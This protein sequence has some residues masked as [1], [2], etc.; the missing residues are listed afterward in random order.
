[1][2]HDVSLVLNVKSSIMDKLCRFL[3]AD[4]MYSIDDLVRKPKLGFCSR[5]HIENYQIVDKD[6]T[7][8]LMFFEGT[9]TNLGCT[10]LLTGAS[11]SELAIIKAIT[12]L[13]I[14]VAYNSKLE[15]SFIMDKYSDFSLKNSN[16]T[17]NTHNA[18]K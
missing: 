17:Y 1:M 14:Y 2:Q 4:P 12:K 9:P 15:Q 6:I 18:H 5:F 11:T 3:Q 13:M 7:K 10:I 16:H 8:S